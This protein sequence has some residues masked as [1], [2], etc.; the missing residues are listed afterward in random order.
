MW[1]CSYHAVWYVMWQCAMQYYCSLLLFLVFSYPT[2][3]NQVLLVLCTCV[4]MFLHCVGLRIHCSQ[5]CSPILGFIMLH[6]MWVAHFLVMDLRLS[7]AFAAL[8]NHQMHAP[9]NGEFEVSRTYCQSTC[10]ARH[11][12]KATERLLL[13]AWLCVRRKF[14]VA[15]LHGSPHLFLEIVVSILYHIYDHLMYKLVFEVCPF[16]AAQPTPTNVP[17]SEIKV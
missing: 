8:T 2:S 14:H 3:Q 10:I 12:L 7:D 1:V 15:T 17:P 13:Y 6:Q 4:C 9:T 11:P 16:V 5:I